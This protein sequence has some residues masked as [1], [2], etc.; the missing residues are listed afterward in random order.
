MGDGPPGHFICTRDATKRPDCVGEENCIPWLTERAEAWKTMAGRLAQAGRKVE[1]RA[2]HF[3][4]H[5]DS[6]DYF[7]L[8]GAL[9]ALL[10][11]LAAHEALKAKYAAE[12]K[13]ARK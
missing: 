4:E 13:A 5:E 10:E 8:L 11:V 1:G 2:R 7:G 9:A 6:G 3:H 12:D